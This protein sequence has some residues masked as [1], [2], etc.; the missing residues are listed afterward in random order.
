[1]DVRPEGGRVS[2]SDL[3]LWCDLE[4]TGTDEATDDI[5]EAAF[6][7]TGP[8]ELSAISSYHRVFRTSHDFLTLD[9]AVARMHNENGLWLQ[10]QGPDTTCHAT[11]D[12]AQVDIL[13]WLGTYLAKGDVIPLAGSGVSHFDRRFIRQTWPDLDRRL[14][15]WHH[16]VGCVRRLARL[17]GV[18]PP[19]PEAKTHRALGD[20]IA[21]IEEARWYVRL[22]RTLTEGA[23]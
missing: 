5:I 8:P 21:H 18:Q 23:H 19:K 22:L 14:T 15:F 13:R 11:D 2:V 9:A 6:V 4:T 3:I 20:V 17:A 1:M 16:D 10:A 7:L 12:D